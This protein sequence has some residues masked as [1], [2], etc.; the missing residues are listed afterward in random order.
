MATDDDLSGESEASWKKESGRHEESRVVSE[1]LGE[2][3]LE[4]DKAR[5]SATPTDWPLIGVDTPTD[6]RPDNGLGELQQGHQVR[7]LPL[8]QVHYEHSQ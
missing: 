3:L 6:C 7:Q 2:G 8:K 4:K 1:D 5:L